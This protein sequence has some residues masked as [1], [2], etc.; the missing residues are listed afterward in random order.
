MNK[1]ERKIYYQNY[2][3]KNKEKLQKYYKQWFDKNKEKNSEKRRLAQAKY[4]NEN[5]EMLF[6]NRKI[7]KL[8]KDCEKMKEL[9]S[10]SVNQGSK[11]K[12]S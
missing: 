1:E 3:E 12:T 6:N 5:K 7:N 11:I 2:K 9:I 4:Y 8:I 10:A